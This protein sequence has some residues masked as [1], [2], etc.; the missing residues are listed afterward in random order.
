MGCYSVTLPLPESLH[1]A[2]YSQGM[3]LQENHGLQNYPSA[4]GGGG[5][6]KPYLA[7]GLRSYKN[8]FFRQ[9]TGPIIGI[10]EPTPLYDITVL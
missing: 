6:G 3:R 5:G 7:S 10:R 9:T 4:V 1:V 8:L 2:K